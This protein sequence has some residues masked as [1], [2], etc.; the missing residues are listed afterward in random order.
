MHIR[1]SGDA[2]ADLHA[3]KSYIESLN[4]RAADRVMVSIFTTIE[5][6]ERFPF[7]GR[8]GESTGRANSRFHAILTSS[9]TR[10]RTNTMSTSNECSTPR[11]NTPRKNERSR[12]PAASV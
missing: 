8:P 3:I 2:R 10:C 12:R 6:L 1:F 9:S 5:Q 7:L 4:P 11:S